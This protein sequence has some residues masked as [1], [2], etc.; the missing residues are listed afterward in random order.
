MDDELGL[1]QAM[2]QSD[3]TAWTVMYERHVGDVFGLIYHLLGEDRRAAEDVS[4]EVWLLA[5]ERFQRFDSSRGRFRDWVLGIARHLALRH[6]RRIKGFATEVC[7]QGASEALPPPDLL[8]AVE[9]AAVVRAALL[10]LD[11]DR[12]RVLLDKYISG[13][14]VVDIAART[15]KSAKAVESLLSRARA[16]FR[17]LLRPYFSNPTEGERHEPSNT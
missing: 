17:G 15:G 4:Q 1:V 14:S 3:R 2:A 16:Q 5:I 13:C 6:H 8:E 11:S 9:R 12:R 10:C 7:P